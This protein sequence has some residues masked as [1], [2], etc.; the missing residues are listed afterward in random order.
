MDG[1]KHPIDSESEKIPRY[2]ASKK[3][4]NIFEIATL[5]QEN[6][7]YFEENWCFKWVRTLLEAALKIYLQIANAKMQRFEF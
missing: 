1:Y 5:V 2:F 6:I 4:Q 7:Q 3:S